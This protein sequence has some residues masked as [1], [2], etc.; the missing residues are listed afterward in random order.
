MGE[1]KRPVS[2][3]ERH[4]GP[5]WPFRRS[6]FLIPRQD[7]FLH[8]CALTHTHT[9]R[10]RERERARRMA[11][12]RS[13][14]AV[15]HSRRRRLGPPAGGDRIATASTRSRRTAHKVWGAW[16]CAVPVRVSRSP[17]V[18]PFRIWQRIMRAQ[19][20]VDV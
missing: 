6:L 19:L 12:T 18:V 16:E 9:H 13:L 1:E 14:C 3:P 20:V 5:S 4:D 2:C 8:V 11:R 7:A 17:L 10:E 15:L